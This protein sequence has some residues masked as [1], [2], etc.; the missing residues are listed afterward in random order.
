MKTFQ[1]LTT[2]AAIAIASS[3]AAQE[4]PKSG[5]TLNAVDPARTARP[6]ARADPERSN[7]DGGRADL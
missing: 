3:L 7:P 5:G 2:A 4:T 6:D 1:Y